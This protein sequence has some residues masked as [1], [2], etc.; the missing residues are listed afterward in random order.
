MDEA[1]EKKRW[2]IALIII[3]IVIIASAG[4]IYSFRDAPGRLPIIPYAFGW[5]A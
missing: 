5:V 3:A 4:M 2:P 1:K